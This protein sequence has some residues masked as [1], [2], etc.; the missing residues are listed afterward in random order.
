MKRPLSAPL[1][2]RRR[3][4]RHRGGAAII[5]DRD[6]VINR[7]IQNGYVLHSSQMEILTSFIDAARISL[8][9]SIPLYVA[10]NQACVGKGLLKPAELHGLMLGLM[11]ALYNNGINI[12]GYVVCPHTV[13]DNCLCRKPR[14]GLL[15]ELQRSYGVDLS[16]SLFVGDSVTDYEAGLAAGCQTILVDEGDLHG[17][18]EAIRSFSQITRTSG[19]CV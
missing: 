12:D 13:A 16:R 9:S 1:K 17:Y 14:P 2:W 4:P 5:F 7:R 11:Q 8:D 3:Q 6:G 15:L 10:S 19:V 18:V